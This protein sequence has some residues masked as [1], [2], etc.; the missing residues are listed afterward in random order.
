MSG[1]LLSYRAEKDDQGYFAFFA[2]PDLPQ[3][4][5]APVSKT[6]LLVVDRSEGDM[7]GQKMEPAANRCGLCLIICTTGICSMSSPTIRSLN[8]FAELQRYGDSTREEAIGFV[9]GLHAGGNTNINGAL[10]RH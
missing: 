9:N 1:K 5:V 2:T 10:R 7:S 4:A 8:N 3:T 6:V